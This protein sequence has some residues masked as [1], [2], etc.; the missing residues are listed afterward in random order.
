MLETLTLSAGFI[1]LIIVLLVWETI[2]KFM[3]MWRASKNNSKGW[4][5]VIGILNTLGILPI[6]YLYVFGKKKSSTKKKRR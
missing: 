6:L 2:W 5:V 4:F 3:G 1:F